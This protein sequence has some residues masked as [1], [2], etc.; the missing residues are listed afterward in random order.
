MVSKR[1]ADIV[2]GV[3]FIWVFLGVASLPLMFFIH[4][5][6]WFLLAFAFLNVF[7]WVVF[8]GCFLSKFENKWRKENN[9]E[10]ALKEGSFIQHYLKRFFNISCSRRVVRIIS[11]S[12][13]ILLVLLVIAIK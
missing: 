13:I 5:W 3:H 4:W 12:Y 7:S 9:P 2:S 10:G 8:G 1:K 6:K 11:Y